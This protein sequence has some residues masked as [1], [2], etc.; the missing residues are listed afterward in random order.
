MH[1]PTLGMLK[2]LVAVGAIGLAAVFSL[3]AC[4]DGEGG[5]DGGGEEQQ[6]EGEGGEDG[7][8]DGEEE[9]D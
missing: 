7:G 3:S 1:T 5:D 6:E 9:D 8:D 4:N 2:R